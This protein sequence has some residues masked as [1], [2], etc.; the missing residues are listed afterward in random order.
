[1]QILKEYFKD[2]LE[3]IAARAQ[4]NEKSN[5]IRDERHNRV[6]A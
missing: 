2:K 1:M 3:A 4:D 5:R 6:L